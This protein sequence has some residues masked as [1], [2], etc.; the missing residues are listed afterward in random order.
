[1]NM[2]F[3]TNQTKLR[4]MQ[5]FVLVWVMVLLLFGKTSAQHSATGGKDEGDIIQMN[6]PSF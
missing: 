4:C 2:L 3:S 6:W 1:M 5:L